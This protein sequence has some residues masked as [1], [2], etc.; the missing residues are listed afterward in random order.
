M[1]TSDAAH[2]AGSVVLVVEVLVVEVLVELVD[3]DVLSL[4]DVEMVL[5]GGDVGAIVLV[6]TDVAGTVGGAVDGMGTIEVVVVVDGSTLDTSGEQ[7]ATSAA[8]MATMP[9][10]R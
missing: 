10:A 7:P 9:V 2:A 1:P 8:E 5:V 3:G 4:I 6:A